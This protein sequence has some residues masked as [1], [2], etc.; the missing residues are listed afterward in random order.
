MKSMVGSQYKSQKSSNNDMLLD[1]LFEDCFQVGVCDNQHIPTPR[2]LTSIEEEQPTAA[3][4]EASGLS[5][6]VSNSIH[7]N[8]ISPFG[9]SSDN[10]RLLMDVDSED[11]SRL[12]TMH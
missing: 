11:V 5:T 3:S 6:K 10:V 1:E 8:S 9:S 7:A 12:L 2:S 4:S